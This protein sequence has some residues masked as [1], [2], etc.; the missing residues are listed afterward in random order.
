ALCEGA[1]DGPQRL[2]GP[3][4]AA[5]DLAQVVGV[6]S[7]FQHFALAEP[8]GSHADIVGVGNNPLHEVLKR[9]FQHVRP[10]PRTYWPRLPRLPC[11]PPWS[12]SCRSSWSSSP[13]PAARGPSARPGTRLPRP[14]GPS[15][16][17]P[18]EGSG[19]AGP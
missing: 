10:R 6:Y 13:G 8:F 3:A 4:V 19:R 9:L 1:D 12:P 18:G 16:R 7:N 17:R 5:D 11:Q 2:G 15:P 14:R